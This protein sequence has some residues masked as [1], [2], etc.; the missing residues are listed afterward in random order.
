MAQSRHHVYG[1]GCT[2]VWIWVNTE[3][4]T[5]ILVFGKR[6]SKTRRVPV[7]DFATVGFLYQ[8][9]MLCQVSG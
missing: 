1:W 5:S 6:L 2:H 9:K 7:S 8:F 4:S 3:M